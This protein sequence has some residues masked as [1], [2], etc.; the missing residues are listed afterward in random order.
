MAS[1][2]TKSGIA[3]WFLLA[4]SLASI[5]CGGTGFVSTHT[6]AP[7]TSPPLI[8][9]SAPENL[10]RGFIP[11]GVP[12]ALRIRSGQVVQI[13]TFSH[14]GFVQDPVTFFK[15]HGISAEM[16]LPDLILA[17]KKHP[18][19]KDGAP[20]VLTGPVYVDGAEPGDTLE[21][22]ILDLKPRVP[23][24]GNGSGPDR[25][26]LPELLTA[27]DPKNYPPRL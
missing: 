8:L 2:L 17:V 27:A 15:N 7:Q 6:S 14:H 10:V 20:H 16:I 13:E 4:G 9:R 5:G 26:G 18:R 21:V 23:Y 3:R 25:G 1:L 12:A 24:G 22:R 11:A 19:P